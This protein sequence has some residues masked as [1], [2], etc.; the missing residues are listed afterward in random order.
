MV[1]DAARLR[2]QIAGLKA[3]LGRRDAAL[4]E[5]RDV[6]EVFVR[7]G[8]Q[9]ELERCRGTFREL[10]SRPPSRTEAPGSGDLT[11]RELDVARC[12]ATRMSN[13]AVARELGISQRTVTTHLSNIY[14][15]LGI[16]SRGELVDR[17]R[18]GRLT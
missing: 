17:V 8:A 2:R 16:G 9:P 10:D 12:V 1:Y 15:K 4:A 6:H 13:K 14:R 18:E 11:G 7:L 3:R 5:L